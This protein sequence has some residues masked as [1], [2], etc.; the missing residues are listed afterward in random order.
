[1]RKK[2]VKSLANITFLDKKKEN[3]KPICSGC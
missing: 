2:K 3:I 1:M